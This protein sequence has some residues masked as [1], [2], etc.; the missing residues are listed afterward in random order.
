MLLKG[1]LKHLAQILETTMGQG[2][3]GALFILKTSSDSRVILEEL[4]SMLQ[5][6]A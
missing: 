2:S 6:L 1:T 3:I 5:H 4:F